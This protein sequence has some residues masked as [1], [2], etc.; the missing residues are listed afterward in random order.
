[1]KTTSL[2]RRPAAASCIVWWLLFTTTTTYARLTN[3]GGCDLAIFATFTV[4]G[5]NPYMACLNTSPNNTENDNVLDADN[6]INMGWSHTVGAALAMEH[7]NQRNASIVPELAD[8]LYRQC[9]IYIDWNRS[10]AFDTETFTHAAARGLLRHVT[11]QSASLQHDD[12]D[13]HVPCAV[14]GPFHDRPALELSTLGAA[15]DMPVVAHRAFNLNVAAKY[16]S[17]YTTQ[18]FPHAIT[19]ATF[20]VSYLYRN[21]RRTDFVAMLHPLSDT[22]VQLSQTV[23]I[24]LDDIGISH[25]QSFAY[26]S[27]ASSPGGSPLRDIDVVL[28]RV[29][30]TGYKTILLMTD[31]PYLEFEYIA[32]AANRQGLTTGD[33]VWCI[34]GDFDIMS[35]SPTAPAE[36]QE[37]LEGSLWISSADKFIMDY[38]NDPFIKVWRELDVDF[39][40]RVRDDLP[41]SPDYPG[42]WDLESLQDVWPEFGTGFMYDAVLTAAM[43]T[44]LAWQ[45]A[46]QQSPISQMPIEAQVAG[47]R[48][49]KFQGASGN[50]SFLQSDDGTH[51]ARSRLGTPHVILN[52]LPPGSNGTNFAATDIMYPLTEQQYPRDERDDYFSFRVEAFQPIIFANGQTTPPTVLRDV[53]MQYLNPEVRILGLT[54]AGVALLASTV[55]A[56]WVYRNRNHRVLQAAQPHFLYLICA[57]SAILILSIIAMSFDESQGWTQQDMNLVCAT[58]PWLSSVGVI[59]V[60]G[61]LFSKLW[62]V[63]RVLQFTRRTIKVKHV[64]WP[65]CACLFIA[66]VTLTV[67]TIVDPPRWGYVTVDEESGEILGTCQADHAGAFITPLVVAAGLPALLTEIMAWKTKDVDNAYS[68]SNWIFIMILVQV[69]VTV[70]AAPMVILLRDVSV[71]G[72]YLGTVSFTWVFAVSP[73][74]FILGPKVY[75]HQKAIHGV[76]NRSVHTRGTGGRGAVNVSGLPTAEKRARNDILDRLSGPSSQSHNHLSSTEKGAGSDRHADEPAVIV[77]RHQRPVSV[78]TPSPLPSSAE[79]QADSAVDCNVERLPVPHDD[80]RNGEPEPTDTEN[81]P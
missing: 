43:G 68:E 3:D 42:N 48:Q 74:V 81:Q 49:A 37:F 80:D 9:P 70:V 77:Q 44:C 67:W 54:A 27:I 55:G 79:E 64:L 10:V 16:H 17:P 57:G 5:Q 19:T 23:A 7:F 52:I 26:N 11:S 58:L 30:Q 36:V 61:A 33:F 60:Y 75:A 76:D 35:T 62:R 18:I 47:M 1:M 34:F 38:E 41:V 65:M 71:N 4:N 15:W 12:D 59:L 28:E 73:V 21:L 51:Y 20:L 24:L 63:Q 25:H 32:A 56:A 50:V 46:Q 69:E 14:V 22:G 53:P 66:L 39:L 31:T 40:R 6:C 13:D 2:P 72:Q 29:Y 8:E 45:N 78:I